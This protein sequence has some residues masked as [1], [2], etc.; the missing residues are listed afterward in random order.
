[1]NLLTPHSGVIFLAHNLKTKQS[2][3]ELQ[4]LN[5]KIYSH[6]MIRVK[7]IFFKAVLLT[8]LLFKSRKAIKYKSIISYT[9]KPYKYLLINEIPHVRAH[10]HYYTVYT[11]IVQSL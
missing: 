6:K 7:F 10:I 11:M 3:G 4:M 9:L 1:M 2:K 8:L 5:K